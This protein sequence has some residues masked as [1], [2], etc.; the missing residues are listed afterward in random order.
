MKNP[1]HK[2]SMRRPACPVHLTQR[3]RQLRIQAKRASWGVDA[4]LITNARDIRYL[5]GFIGDDSWAVVPVR[6]RSITVLTDFRFQEQIQHEAA[7]V[8]V[9]IRT[10]SIVD[11]LK[12]YLNDQSYEKV[13][14]QANHVTFAQ[15][16][17]LAKKIGAR[18]LVPVEDGLIKL[19]SVKDEPELAAIRK[20]LK[21]QEEA[22]RRTIAWLKPG[23]TEQQIAAYLE[24]QMRSLGADRPSFPT[25]IAADANASLPHAVPGTRKI[26]KGGMLL[27]DWGARWNGYCSDLTR[28]IGIGKMPP[29]IREIYQI[30]LEAQQ[31]AIN[32]I[33]PG[34]PLK[35]IDA[36]A[37]K[38]IEN[39]GYGPYFGHS[40]GHGLGL[41]IHEL[42]T[43]SSRSEGVLKPGHVI[44]VEPGIYLPGV[45]GVRIEDDV[46]VTAKGRRVLSQLP[47]DLESAI[48]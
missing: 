38:V 4:V 3:I 22:Y 39:A 2:R 27:I 31:V 12:S 43:L 30:V 41:N 16:S 8:A 45:G 6:S 25:I 20:A 13:A 34:K 42:P 29:K 21:I 35:E 36:V 17:A 9:R 33:K 44:T 19:R 1:K 48:I 18:N 47:T 5:T 7:H 46:L 23:L 15:R 24:Y 37:R 14:I 32:A 40:L 26:K 11:E 10:G 28:V